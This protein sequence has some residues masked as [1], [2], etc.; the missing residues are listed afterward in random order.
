M[1]AAIKPMIL[2]GILYACVK[3]QC[4][5]GWRREVEAAEEEDGT[6]LMLM[7]ELSVPVINIGGLTAK[8]WSFGAFIYCRFHL[9]AGSNEGQ[10]DRC[11]FW[12]Q[13][14][15]EKVGFVFRLF[16]LASSW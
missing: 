11:D 6:L 12:A 10:G 2:R 1:I 14:E 15:E 16:V 7:R 13:I 9:I 3:R 4:V 5:C 8:Q